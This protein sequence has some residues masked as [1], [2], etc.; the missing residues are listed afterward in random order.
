MRTAVEWFANRISHGGL[1]SKKQ[2]D[3]LLKQAKEMEKVQLLQ[4]SLKSAHY[5]RKWILEH[6]T[7]SKYNPSKVEIR[8]LE[9]TALEHYNET[10]KQQEQ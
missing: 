4:M 7:E 1:V 6:S 2:F 5:E 10:F 3:E 9:K 8:D